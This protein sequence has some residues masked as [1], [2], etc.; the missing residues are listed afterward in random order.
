MHKK[1]NPKKNEGA[2]IELGNESTLSGNLLRFK[3]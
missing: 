2:E 1:D 3:Y